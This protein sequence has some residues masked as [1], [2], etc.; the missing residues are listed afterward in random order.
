MYYHK[1]CA[2]CQSQFEAVRSDANYCTAL[3]RTKASQHR[4]AVA[5]FEVNKAK[6][7]DK[8]KAALQKV[9]DELNQRSEISNQE[10]AEKQEIQNTINRLNK[11]VSLDFMNL[12]KY[13]RQY[14]LK[15][16]PNQLDIHYVMIKNLD[17]YY[18]DPTHRQMVVNLVEGFRKKIKQRVTQLTHQNSGLDLI[19][20]TDVRLVAEKINLEDQIKLC[21]EQQPPQP[22]RKETPDT[23]K[24]FNQ[25]KRK[26]IRRSF[27]TRTPSSNPEEN[28]IF[29]KEDLSAEDVLHMT[30]DTYMLS[31]EL[32]RFLGEL[33][34]NKVAFA[35]TGD[36][37]AGKSYFSFELARLFL[38]EGKT[39]KYYSLEEGIGKL[40]Q[41]KLI[42]YDIG[43]EMKITDYAD[44]KKIRKD[45]SKYD[46]LIIDSYSKIATDPK[47]FENL[48]QSFPKTL[49]IV[50]FQKTTG[51]TIRGG[52][53]IKY[54]SSATINVC[55]LGGE[56]VAE[57]E[58][59]RYGTQ[60]WVYSIDQE[61]IIKEH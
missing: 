60:G 21:E 17:D 31:G 34:H 42:K 47:D 8:L 33:D 24:S 1:V 13:Y 30:F 20:L 23:I 58:K 51:K 32:G 28:E 29:S 12:M 19:D 61:K 26:P 46:V 52:S 37:G 22:E 54:N 15:H 44:L 55:F 2:Y 3:C 50:I 49:F 6:E 25:R 10:Q 16:Y 35:L 14:E 57:M 9:E 59:G 11:I 40:T 56:R 43:D 53:S 7:I 27:G 48:R 38:D 39:V 41:E 45:A 4:K 18:N 5:E 36:S